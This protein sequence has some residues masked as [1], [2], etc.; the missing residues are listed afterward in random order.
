MELSALSVVFSSFTFASLHSR[1]F[2]YGASNLGTFFKILT[3]SYLNG[4][5]HARRWRHLA[6][7]NSLDFVRGGL[8]NMHHCC[9]FPLTLAMLFC[10]FLLFLNALQL[11]LAEICRGCKFENLV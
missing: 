3:F 10:T 6:Y 1:N 5:S 4:S 7:V 9:V 8:L 2:L 11:M